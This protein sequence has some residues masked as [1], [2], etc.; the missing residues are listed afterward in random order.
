MNESDRNLGMGTDIS[1]R[2]FLNGCKLAVGASLL[3]GAV[4]AQ[5]SYIAAQDVPNYYPPKFTGMRG[6]HWLVQVLAVFQR[7]TS[8]SKQEVPIQ[9]SLFSKIMMILAATPNAMSF[10]SIVTTS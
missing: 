10:R 5:D 8:T 9:K 4:L 7:P 3:P 1:R 6:S 2:D